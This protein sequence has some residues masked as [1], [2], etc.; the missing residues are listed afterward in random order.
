MEEER[1]T[2]GTF[3]RARCGSLKRVVVLSGAGISAESGVPTFRGE[4][5]YWTVGSTVY[6][7]QELATWSHFSRMPAEIWRWYLH[8][9][10]VCHEAEPNAA[11]L[12]LVALEEALGDGFTLVTQNVDGLHLRAGNTRART[13]E[14][15][16]NIDFMRPVD[17]DS[18]TLRPIP[19]SVQD[20]LREGDEVLLRALRCDQTGVACRPHVLW[21]DECYDED[22]FRYESALRATASADLLVIVGTSGATNLPTQMVSLAAQ[23]QIPFVDINLDWNTFG[24]AASKLPFALSLRGKAGDLLPML[25]AELN[26]FRLNN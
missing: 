18:T 2:V 22:L 14:I 9:R 16:G 19:K 1:E 21:F 15:H 11:H 3:L 17:G 4:E 10:S 5:G 8:R 20:G 25:V 6:R 12:A 7:P 13:Y 23:S 24:H 26:A